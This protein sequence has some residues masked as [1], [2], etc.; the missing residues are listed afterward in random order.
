MSVIGVSQPTSLV[1]QYS[2]LQRNYLWDVLLPDISN[3]LGKMFG[4]ILE[5]V[6]GLAMTQYVQAVK[7]GDYDI[8][9]NVMKYGPY[10]AKFPGL[11][12]V[13]DVT[14]TFL[15]PMPDFISG[16]FYSWKNLIVDDTGLYF[17]KNKYQKNVYVRFLD[18]T[19]LAINRY[20]LTGCFPVKFPSYNMDYK[21]NDVT[22]F[23]V[24]LAV[25]KIEIE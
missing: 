5:G 4:G 3:P 18:S 17:P 10:Q 7:F 6:Q 11:L 25:D 15:K 12:D 21:N 9:K 16:Y 14:I 13:G 20:K 24:T 1:L 2:R 23:D 22:Q 19:G 8:A